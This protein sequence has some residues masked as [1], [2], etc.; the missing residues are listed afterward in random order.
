MSPQGFSSSP[1]PS[2][3]TT[4]RPTYEVCVAGLGSLAGDDQAGWRVIERLTQRQA[5]GELPADRIRLV[6]LGPPAELLDLLPVQRRLV[7]VDACRGAVAPGQWA[8]FRWPAPFLA[9]TIGGHHLPL[10]AALELAEALGLLPPHC[11]IWC[12]GGSD[13]RLD[14]PP[15]AAVDEAVQQLA[16]RLVAQ[17]QAE[18]ST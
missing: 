15:T 5:A 3:S 9:E 10:V 2:F 4:Q 1:P 13:F 18:H 16:D 14:V 7:V 12:V 17:L 6:R 8:R 11:D